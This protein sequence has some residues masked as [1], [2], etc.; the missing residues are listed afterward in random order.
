M[1]AMVHLD[2]HNYKTNKSS[3][4]AWYLIMIF[5]MIS[6]ITRNV[7]IHILVDGSDVVG[8]DT[9]VCCWSWWPLLIDEAWNFTSGDFITTQS[10]HMA[11][12][13]IIN[14][15]ITNQVFWTI[16]CRKPVRLQFTFWVTSFQIHVNFLW[17]F[18]R[19]II[20]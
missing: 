19:G 20:W 18:I 7:W 14:K 13:N 8:S 5:L 9:R 10:K 4:V 11:V 2:P 16:L 17:S 15:P 3:W 1:G 6:W 12:K